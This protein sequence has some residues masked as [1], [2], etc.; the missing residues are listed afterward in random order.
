M[1]ARGR[2]SASLSARTLLADLPAVADPLEAG[3]LP[4]GD[5]LRSVG[6]SRGL[7]RLRWL[8]RLCCLALRRV[9]GLGGLLLRS[10]GFFRRGLRFVGRNRPTFALGRIGLPWSSIARRLLR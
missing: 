5:L 9:R 4:R 10:L 8:L 6:R 1:C 7:L 3:R 2:L